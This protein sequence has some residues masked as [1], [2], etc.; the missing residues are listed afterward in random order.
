MAAFKYFAKTLEGKTVTGSIQASTADAA[1]S[2]LRTQNLAVVSIGENKPSAFMGAFMGKGKGRVKNEDVVLFTRQLATMVSAGIP[3]LESLEVLREQSTNPAFKAVLDETVDSVRSG[4]DL[5]E[6]MGQHTR[7]FPK[8]YVNMIRA[9]EASGQLDEILDRLADYQE[10]AAALKREIKGAMTYP[11]VSL[12][13]IIGITIFLLVFII[14]KFKPIFEALGGI[15][16]LP[17]PTRILLGLSEFLQTYILWI[18]LGVVFFAVALVS[19]IR[20]ERGQ[21]Q[22]DWVTLQVPVFG[23]LFQKVAI[24]RFARTFAT[25][26]ESGVPILGALEIVSQT[27]GNKVIEIA[28]NKARESIRHGESLA[29]P[30]GES[31]VFPPMVVKMIAIGEKSGALETL[32]KKVSMFYD[33]QV[34]ASVEGLTALIEPLMIGIMGALV[35]GIVLAVFLPILKLQSKLTGGG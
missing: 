5:S 28:V 7:A 34:R 13:M 27:A 19:Y 32:L 16:E 8:I 23:P 24:S 9:G 2:Q 18:G 1:I 21:K 31:P 6:A 10:E 15:N 3:L 4:V 14:P 29:K 12:C 30:L 26:I 25:L 20:T 11:V 17:A 22:F 33:R 35:G